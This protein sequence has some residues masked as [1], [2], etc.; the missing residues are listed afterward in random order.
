MYYEISSTGQPAVYIHLAWSHASVHPA[1]TNNRQW[2]AVDLQGHGRT[3]NIDRRLSFEQHADVIAALLEHLKIEQADFFGESFGGT[4]AVMKA[5]RH[6]KLVRRVAAYGAFLSNLGARAGL[7]ADSDVFE[8]QRENYKKVAPDPE[9]WPT[10]FATVLMMEWK[11]FARDELNSIKAPVLIVS[12]DHD[13]IPV[14]RSLEWSRLIPNAQFAVIPDAGHFVLNVDPEKL[15]PTVARYLDA[16][17][18]G[19]PFA[20]PKTGFHPGVNR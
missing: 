7:S 16:P 9:Q 3:A 5:V 14:E 11:G 20:T 2:I 18:P 10:V 12:G 6:P 15:L 4:V 17:L 8:F 13:F 19:L 1:L